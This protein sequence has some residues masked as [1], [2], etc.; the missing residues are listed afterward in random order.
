MKTIIQQ[1][2]IKTQ[3][4]EKRDSERS[5]DNKRRQKMEKEMSFF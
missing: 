1:L 5:E 2:Q 4:V 3:R